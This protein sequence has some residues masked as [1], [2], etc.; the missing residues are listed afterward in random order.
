[1]RFRYF[2]FSMSVTEVTTLEQLNALC[3]E[4]GKVLVDFHATWC[5]PC[6]AIAP[7]VTEQ[8]KAQGIHLV[9]VDVDEAGE[10]AAKYTVQAMPTFKVLDGGANAVFEKVGG[11]KANVEACFAKIKEM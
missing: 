9:K 10:I 4:H 3:K 7:Y 5:G 1:M 6:K 2:K 11:G 8:S